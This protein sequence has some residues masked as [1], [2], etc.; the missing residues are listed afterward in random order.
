[1]ETRK[2]WTS[3]DSS[4]L[5]KTRMNKMS[6]VFVLIAIGIQVITDQTTRTDSDW[7]PPD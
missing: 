7:I 4:L 1:M 3:G 2:R 6:I 5:K